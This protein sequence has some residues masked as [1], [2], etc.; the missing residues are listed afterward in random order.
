[1]ICSSSAMPTRM[2]K[3]HVSGKKDIHLRLS[4]RSLIYL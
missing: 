3:K 2:E 4:Y 1:M